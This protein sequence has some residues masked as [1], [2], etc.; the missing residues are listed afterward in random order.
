M[1][2][3]K[4]MDKVSSKP[5][6]TVRHTVP[7]AKLTASHAQ[8]RGTRVQHFG[9]EVWVRTVTTA[10]RQCPVIG[11][12]SLWS[13]CVV[14][15]AVCPCGVPAFLTLGNANLSLRMSC[16]GSTT[17]STHCNEPSKLSMFF[18]NKNDSQAQWHDDAPGTQLHHRQIPLQ[19]TRFV[20]PH[21]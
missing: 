8:K 2:T 21:V 14:A 18:S 10:S 13:S 20:T 4:N 6:R 1:Q 7:G 11:Q 17:V 12:C 15:G 3:A 5:A 9:S 19:M 16:I